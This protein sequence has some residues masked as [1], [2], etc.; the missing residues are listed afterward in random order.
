M[1]ENKLT[2]EQKES[3]N[4]EYEINKRKKNNVNLEK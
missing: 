1:G 4:K 2:I 3:K